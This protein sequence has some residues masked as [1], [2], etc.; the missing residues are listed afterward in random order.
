MGKRRFHCVFLGLH[1]PIGRSLGD[2][3]GVITI[4]P[5]K[6]KMKF[7]PN[8]MS[9][10]LRRNLL[11][12]IAGGKDHTFYGTDVSTEFVDWP[13]VQSGERTGLIHIKITYYD[14]INWD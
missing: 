9:G 4:P 10:R 3:Y 14:I 13:G 2:S 7:D 11:V 1:A 8:K 12:L 5:D 6:N